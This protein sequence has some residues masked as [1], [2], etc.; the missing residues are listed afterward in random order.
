MSLFLTMFMQMSFAE[1]TFSDTFDIRHFRPSSDA[2]QYFAVPSASTLRHLQMGISL[3]GLYENDPFVLRGDDY[4]GRYVHPLVVAGG[5]TGDAPVDNRFIGNVQ[6]GIGF[7]DRVSISVDLPLVFWQSGYR[8]DA[9]YEPEVEPTYMLESG[10]GDF[11]IQPKLLLLDR[12][13]H[14]IGLA[15]QMPVSFPSSPKQ[16]FLG[17]NGTTLTPTGILEFSDG[18][19]RSKEYRIRASVFAS[20]H[21]RPGGYILEDTEPPIAIGNEMIFGGAIGLK[22][23]N[24]LEIVGEI[25]SHNKKDLQGLPTATT[26]ESNG[27]IKI[28][29]G[30]HIALNFGGGGTFVRS[31]GTPDY[32]ATFSV[33]V[34]PDLDPNVRDPDQD[35]IPSVLDECPGI[36]ED[37]DKFQDDDGCPDY[38]NDQDGLRDEIDQCPMEQEDKDGFQDEDGCAD[39]DN[40]QDGVVDRF[41]RCPTQAENKNGYLDND[42]CPDTKQSYSDTDYDEI[43]DNEDQCPFKPED[44][45]NFEDSDG[46][47]DLD[48]DQDGVPDEID[49][50]ANSREVYNG[51]DDADGCPDQSAR[52]RVEKDSIKIAEKIFFDFGLSTI[53]PE[54]YGLLDELASV[55]LAYPE[56]QK[57]HVEGHTD[58]IGSAESN[59][60]LSKDRAISVRKALVDRGVEADRLA[61]FGYGEKRPVAT[62]ETDEGREQNR[63]VEFIIVER[64]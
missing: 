29:S 11:S 44:L 38:D 22:P 54:S 4:N 7:A 30:R 62:N 47:P 18:P 45:D 12:D 8:M 37:V 41:D 14:P 15:F 59:L 43:P 3:W 55:I 2:H 60:A 32:R 17:E 53:K 56:L 23:F 36:A 6:V 63:R 52:I 27:G 5:D 42:G 9:F 25:I 49:Q 35:G 39:T 1:G 28:H 24:F 20:Y 50:C 26:I 51:V 34:A 10:M 48:N 16:S 19:I 21:V 33:V 64:E 61:A 31:V 58:N 13:K 57:I 40:D 46:C